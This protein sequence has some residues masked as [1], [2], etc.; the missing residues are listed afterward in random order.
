LKIKKKTTE[1]WYQYLK[2]SAKDR[3]RPIKIANIPMKNLK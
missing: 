2:K 1:N 3:C